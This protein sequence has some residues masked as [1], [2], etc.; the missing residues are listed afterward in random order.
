MGSEMCIRDSQ[1]LVQYR[2]LFS[3]YSVPPSS[4]EC[5]SAEESKVQKH[6]SQHY[7]IDTRTVRINSSKC[8]DLTRSEVTGKCRLIYKQGAN[9]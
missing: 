9:K 2:R 1:Y 4:V 6:R 3:K 5:H 7:A 8:A